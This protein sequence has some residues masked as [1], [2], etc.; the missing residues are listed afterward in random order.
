MAQRPGSGSAFRALSKDHQ[1]AGRELSGGGSGKSP[2]K[3]RWTKRICSTGLD[4][5]RVPSEEES[6]GVSEAGV[7]ASFVE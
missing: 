1:C 2:S 5:S 7:E 4:T 3:A 6:E